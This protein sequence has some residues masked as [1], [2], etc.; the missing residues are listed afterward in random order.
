MIHDYHTTVTTKSA[1]IVH[2]WYKT[3]DCP[4]CSTCFSVAPLPFK[5]NSPFE[6]PTKRPDYP[7][8]CSSCGKGYKAKP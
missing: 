7:Y 3:A 8:V 4:S 5:M 2:P 6:P 1:P